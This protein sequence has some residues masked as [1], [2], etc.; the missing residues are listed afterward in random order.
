MIVFGRDNFMNINNFFRAKGLS[1][2][3]IT[4]GDNQSGDYRQRYFRSELRVDNNETIHIYGDGHNANYL[5]E[6]FC[7]AGIKVVRHES[8]CGLFDIIR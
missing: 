5:E 3:S 2:Y 4:T 1:C 7:T 8:I 6:E